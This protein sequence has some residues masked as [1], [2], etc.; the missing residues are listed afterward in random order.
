MAAGGTTALL[1][2]YRP[3][4]E[5]NRMNDVESLLKTRKFHVTRLIYDRFEPARFRRK[6][7]EVLSLLR[8]RR[9]IL[10][11]STMSKLATMLVLNACE[12]F[13]LGLDLCY[14]E[15]RHYGPTK[16]EFNEAK[17]RSQVH[18]PSS[19]IFTGVH[20]VVRVK[21]LASVA[22]QGQPTAAIAFMSF[23]NALT[24]ALLNTVYPTRLFLINGRPPIHRWREAATAWVHETLR[25]EWR[26][27]NPLSSADSASDRIPTRV[28]ST[29]DYRETVAVLLELYWGLSSSHRILLAPTGSKMQTVACSIVKALHPD[30]HIEYPSAE[31]FTMDYSVGVRKSWCVRADSLSDLIRRVRD[32]ERRK[33]LGVGG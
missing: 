23:N 26:D 20:G 28:T 5:D 8:P 1:L 30:I 24:Q 2:D 6:F 21:S 29:L 16:D 4:N 25:Q 15:A 9:V 7:R 12:G 14:T 27:D 17:H 22:M 11:I 32:L 10:D 19:Q 3:L 18:R 13:N 31:G 33:W